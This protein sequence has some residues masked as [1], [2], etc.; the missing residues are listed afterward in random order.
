MVITLSRFHVK[1]KQF[2]NTINSTQTRHIQTSVNIIMDTPV[3][4]TRQFKTDLTKNADCKTLSGVLV[5]A[6]SS[7][8]WFCHHYTQ[9]F[10]DTMTRRRRGCNKR[11]TCSSNTV[12]SSPCLCHKGYVHEVNFAI[13]CV[14]TMCM[15]LTESHTSR[16]VSYVLK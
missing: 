12:A 9:A 2:L 4:I 14:H 15:Y 11:A 6:S 8:P 1:R 7:R 10:F 5:E 16:S 13:V 3:V